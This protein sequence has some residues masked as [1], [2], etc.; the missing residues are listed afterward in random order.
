MEE[1]EK[2]SNMIMEMDRES[3]E[4]EEEEV[5]VHLVNYYQGKGLNMDQSLK[6][7]IERVKE[8]KGQDSLRIKT[9]YVR[10]LEIKLG[11]PVGELVMKPERRSTNKELEPEDLEKGKYKAVLLNRWE[12]EEE[13][14]WEEEE[15]EMLKAA[16]DNEVMVITIGKKGLRGGERVTLKLGNS[17]LLEDPMKSSRMVELKK[18]Q[19]VVISM[20][21]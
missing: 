8:V 4:L 17:I 19:E 12:G 16:R 20:R 7:A 13:V 3:I 9:K 14:V 1:G 11:G 15:E 10:E 2:N 21:G 18:A 5:P 6:K